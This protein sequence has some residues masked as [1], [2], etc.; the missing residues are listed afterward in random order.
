MEGIIAKLLL[1]ICVVFAAANPTAN[2]HA[3]PKSSHKSVFVQQSSVISDI[4]D[5]LSVS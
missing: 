2:A 1:A 3:L 4:T 5:A